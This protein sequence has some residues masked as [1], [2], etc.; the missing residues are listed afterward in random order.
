MFA[1]ELRA[2][3]DT[4]V[5]GRISDD[6]KAHYEQ[7]KPLLDYVVPR[8]E[9]VGIRQ[10]RILMAKD[11]Q[12]MASYLRRGRVDWVTETS[13]GGM[14][15]AERG[16]A[17]PLLRTSRG[18][19]SSY[20]T[21]FFVR[22][23]SRIHS[24]AQLRGRS[25]AFQNRASTSAYFMPADELL[26]QGLSLEQLLSPHDQPGPDAVGFMFARSERNIVTWVAKGLV[27]AGAINDGDWV[28]P[29]RVPAAFRDELRLIHTGPRLPRGIEM[30]GT[31][32]P[33]AVRKRLREVL[34]AARHD[35]AAAPAL[36]AFFGTTAFQPI[37]AET[38]AQLAHIRA[39]TVRVRREVE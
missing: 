38:R 15:L 12:Q 21:V 11:V 34:L 32:V 23:G 25:V 13:A 33:G 31:R 9:K 29:S 4:L 1:P 2:E 20:A 6:P 18:G 30:V 3:G 27:D 39:A 35:P 24:L 8:M 28:S 37:D 14:L 17:V 36:K 16:G 19:K 10:G 5:L 7:L 26:D 22:R